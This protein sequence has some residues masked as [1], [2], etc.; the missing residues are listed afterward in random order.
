[1]RLYCDH[2]F[3]TPSGRARFLCDAPLGLGEPPCEAFPLVLTVGRYLGHWHTMT[4]TGKVPRLNAMHPEPLLEVHPSDAQRYGVDDGAWAQVSSRRGTVA[5]RVQVTDRIRPG[6]LFLPMHWGGSQENACEANTLMH[7]LFCPHS[8]QPE[9]KAAAVRLEA[10]V[11]EF[12]EIG[13]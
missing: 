9:L 13:A 6:T 10:A 12:G 4:R 3:P 7:E 5:A 11:Q 2:L 8:R 1:M